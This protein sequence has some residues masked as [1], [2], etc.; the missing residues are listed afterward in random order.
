MKL[1][2][3]ARCVLVDPMREKSCQRFGPKIRQAVALA[4][5]E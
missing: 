2:G 4:N 3:A 5:I 1:R